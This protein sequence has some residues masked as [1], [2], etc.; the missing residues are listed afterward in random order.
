[1]MQ[2]RL[3]L[4]IIAF[5]AILSISISTCFAKEQGGSTNGN[6]FAYIL[7]GPPASGKGSLSTAMTKKY[8]KLK[9]ISVGDLLRQNASSGQNSVMKNGALVSS[10]VV[11]DLVKKELIRL[12]K[13]NVILDGIPRNVEQVKSLNKLLGDLNI[14]VKN[15]LF[16]NN[17][18]IETLKGRMSN[19]VD[20]SKASERRDD[21]NEETF[22]KRLNMYNNNQIEIIGKYKEFMANKIISL[23]CKD[24]YKTWVSVVEKAS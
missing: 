6:R 1:M 8:P 4:N 5:F 2:S 19:R 18:D 17:C 13:Y 22:K 24:N 14:D 16:I 3:T 10:E 23:E 15:I 21:D 12:E 11:I 7:I 9:H 20:Q